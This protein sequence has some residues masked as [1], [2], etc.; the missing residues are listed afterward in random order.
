MDGQP[1]YVAKPVPGA[2]AWV[3]QSTPPLM[4]AIGNAVAM[5]VEGGLFLIDLKAKRLM[6]TKLDTVGRQEAILIDPRDNTVFFAHSNARNNELIISRVN[7]SAPTERMETTTLPFPL[8]HVV[9]D[10]NPPAGVNLQYNRPRAVSLSMTDNALFVS[11]ATKIS[12]LDKKR[13]TKLQTIDLGFPCRLIQVRRGTLPAT[14]TPQGHV[15][16]RECNL[17]WAIGSIYIGTGVELQ[18][19]RYKLYKIAVV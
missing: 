2:P 7:P 12:M 8:T 14:P 5:C 15:G 16:P 3:S 4:D 19:Y 17:I 11:H 9:T 10:Q 13:L 6:G 1:G 18:K